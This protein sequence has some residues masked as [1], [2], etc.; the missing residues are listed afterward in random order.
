MAEI[1]IMVEAAGWNSISGLE[2]LVEKAARAV[3]ANEDAEECS[4]SIL[5]AD[6]ATLQR[7]NATFRHKDKPTN[8][9]SFPAPDMPGQDADF[10]GD[11]ALSH[12]TCAREAQEE[13][14]SLADHMMHLVVHGTLHLLGYD[15]ENEAEAEEMEALEVA[16]L[17][18]LGIKNPYMGAEG[19]PNPVIT[20]PGQVKRS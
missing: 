20:G 17:A 5:L 19:A 2:A 8:V 9:L 6:D 1:D 11:L 3:L 18:S 12:D 13:G 16:V 15:H 10:L 7:L 14:K 4:L